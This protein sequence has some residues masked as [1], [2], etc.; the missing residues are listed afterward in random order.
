VRTLT[1]TFRTLGFD[2]F[3]FG[4]SHNGRRSA[5]RLEMPEETA[6]VEHAANE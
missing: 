2:V 1:H 6:G 4:P 3:G 5:R